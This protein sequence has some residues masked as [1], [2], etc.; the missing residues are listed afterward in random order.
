M[1][2]AGSGGGKSS[3]NWQ[4]PQKKCLLE[5]GK[6]EYVAIPWKEDTEKV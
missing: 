3:R 1:K 5:R 2:E 4:K 6:I